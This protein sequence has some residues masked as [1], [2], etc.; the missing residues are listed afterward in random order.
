MTQ[1]PRMIR[2]ALD[3]DE[4]ILNELNAIITMLN[5]VYE[6]AR[7]NRSDFIRTAIQ[8]HLQQERQKIESMIEFGILL[9]RFKQ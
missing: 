2:I 5:Q 7:V 4:K 6:P 8:A 9:K 3:L 1:K